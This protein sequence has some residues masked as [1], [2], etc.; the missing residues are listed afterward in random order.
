MLNCSQFEC[1]I[2]ARTAEIREMDVNF[3]GGNVEIDL[4]F[5]ILTCLSVSV[6]LTNLTQQ[7]DE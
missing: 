2:F 5:Y 7:F 4:R 6:H 1:F 3:W